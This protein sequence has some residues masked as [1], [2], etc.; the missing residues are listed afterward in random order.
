MIYPK[1]FNQ[2][3]ENIVKTDHKDIHCFET[4]FDNANL[5]KEVV[6]SFG[7]EWAK[8][9]SFTDNDIANIG[10]RY[11]DIIDRTIINENTYMIDIGCGSGRWS[12]YLSDRVGFI[13]AIDPSEAIIA[14]NNLL[15]SEKNI[16]LSKASIDNLPFDD[17]TFDFGMSIGV[18]HH[19]PNTPKALCDCVKKIK[20]GGF[21]YIYLYYNL[22][23]KG[24]ISKWLF[25]IITLIRIIV[26]RLPSVI[27]K[28][29]CDIL[30]LTFYMPI[31]MLGRIIKIIG[32]NSIAQKLPLNAYQETS[33]FIIRND[34]LD[35]F[36]TKLEQ[37]FSKKQII[38]MMENANLTDIKV[39]DNLPYWHAVGKRI[40]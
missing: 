7:E 24:L 14:A 11:F 37:R 15:K 5:D 35:R 16:R 8:F 39:S 17:E 40:M 27:K 10:E 20:I 31:I 4:P 19:I 6:K 26:S 18:L 36:G 34:S 33:F 29:V 32:F 13:E 23:N 21:F 30:A 25:N 28:F 12:K 9:N 38:E 1:R 3:P 22:D 2:K